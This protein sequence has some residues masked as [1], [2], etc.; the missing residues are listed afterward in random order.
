MMLVSQVDL[1]GQI[2]LV[3]SNH[4]FAIW[5]N[6]IFPRFYIFIKDF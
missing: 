4:I 1:H 2:H 6:E 3:G 5:E